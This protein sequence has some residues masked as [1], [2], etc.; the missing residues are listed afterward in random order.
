[1]LSLKRGE[2]PLF[3][4]WEVNKLPS[5]VSIIL[6]IMKHM[7]ESRGR[8]TMPIGSNQFHFINRTI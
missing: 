5:I 3:G 1:M 8:M 4:I 7:S 6:S 2:D